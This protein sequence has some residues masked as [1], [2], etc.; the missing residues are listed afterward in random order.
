MCVQ[1]WEASRQPAPAPGQNPCHPNNGGCSH[2]CLL[3]PYPPGYSC[4]CPIGIRLLNNRTC[5]SGP[6]EVLLYAVRTEISILYL[7]SEDYTHRTLP[8][9]GIKYSIAVDYDPVNEYLYWTD[10]EVK[11]I[12]RARLNGSNQEDIIVSDIHHNDGLAIDWLAGNLYWTDTGSD[13][14]EV[15]RL[16]GSFRRV[17]IYEGLVEPRAIVVAPEHGWLFWSDWY[18]KQPKIERAVLDGSNRMVLVNSSLGWPNGLTLDFGM[19]KIYWCD[20]KIDKI[21]VANMDGSDRMELIF[22]NL[23]H[24]FG[25]SLMGDYIYW[26]DWQRRA[27]DRAHKLTGT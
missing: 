10:D 20:A 24:T 8:L 22:D 26:T 3:A 7:D 21:E 23:P 25:L 12:R 18:E 14:I 13:H 17:L 5:A 4:A 6:E 19:S 16:N 1:T 9:D 2:L 27:I 11:A 15:C